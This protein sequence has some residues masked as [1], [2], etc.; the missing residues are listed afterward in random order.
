MLLRRDDE[1]ALLD[2]DT[3]GRPSGLR[4]HGGMT[5]DQEQTAVR[6]SRGARRRRREQTFDFEDD[7]RRR[8]FQQVGGSLIAAAEWP[9][10]STES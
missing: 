4:T 6:R 8:R 9:T 2:V 10:K 1:R 3:A 5:M 7:R